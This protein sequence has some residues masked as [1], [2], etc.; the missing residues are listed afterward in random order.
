MNPNKIF[1]GSFAHFA[2]LLAVV[3]ACLLS[4]FAGI[5]FE[6]IL[7][8]SAA[9]S[10]WMRNVQLSVFAIPSSFIASLLQVVLLTFTVTI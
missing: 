1:R 7:K 2:G 6:K 8:S 5:H 4:G 3:C 9:V 10:I